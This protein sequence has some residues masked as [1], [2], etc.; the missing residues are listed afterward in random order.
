MI[1]FRLLKL[2]PQPN[3]LDHTIKLDS[4]LVFTNRADRQKASAELLGGRLSDGDS[5][6]P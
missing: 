5:G 4:R 3:R 2:N 6:A 1:E